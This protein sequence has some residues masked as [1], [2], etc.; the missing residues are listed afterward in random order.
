MWR[1]DLLSVKTTKARWVTLCEVVLRWLD[2]NSSPLLYE[3]KYL[4]ACLETQGYF[5][6]DMIN[7]PA[8]KIGFK[9]NYRRWMGEVQFLNLNHF[10]YRAQR[11]W[12]DLCWWDKCRDKVTQ[13]EDWS[14][15]SDFHH[16]ISSLLSHVWCCRSDRTPH[17]TLQEA[18]GLYFR[19]A[20]LIIK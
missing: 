8:L 10:N 12:K 5:N 17:I 15:Q 9:N 1:F 18:E 7:N 19:A 13:S 20:G 14:T 4:P 3:R 6:Y 2:M 11:T 16:I